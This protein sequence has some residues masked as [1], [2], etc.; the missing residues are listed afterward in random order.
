[1]RKVLF[2]LL[3]SLTHFHIINAIHPNKTERPLMKDNWTYSE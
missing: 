1:M 3:K 2:V